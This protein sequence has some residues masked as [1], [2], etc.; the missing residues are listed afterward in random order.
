MYHANHL[1]S[2]DCRRAVAR[3]VVQL[4][5][6]AESLRNRKLEAKSNARK[7]SPVYGNESIMS[8]AEN[9]FLSHLPPNTP[10]FRYDPQCSLESLLPP[11][12]PYDCFVVIEAFPSEVI[13]ELDEQLPGRLDYSSQLRT[14]ILKM[15]S[16][17]HEEAAGKFEGVLTVLATQMKVFRQLHYLGATRVDG[18]DRKKQADRAWMPVRQGGQFPTVALEVGYPE[19]AA[20]LEK[21]ITWWL[22]ASKGRVK[23]GITIDIKRGSGNIEIKSWV[24]EPVP[25]HI[26]IT[27]H[28]RQVVDRRCNTQSPPQITQRIL[29]KKGKNGQEPTITGGD[30]VIPFKSLFLTEPGEGESDFVMTEDMLVHDIAELVWAAIE[31]E[32][33]KKRPN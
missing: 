20:K 29:I 30:L 6:F 26:Y 2:T 33:A 23:M 28:Q 11:I 13:D 5:H 22:H 15:P 1:R 16:Q 8:D 17:P 25:Q 32:E 31:N 19:T 3:N 10:V 14:L 24:T 21:D 7:M 4:Q 12:S 18:K 9:E 27:M